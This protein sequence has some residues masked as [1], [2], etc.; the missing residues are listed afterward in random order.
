[1]FFSFGFFAH[2]QLLWSDVLSI[3]FTRTAKAN[4]KSEQVMSRL[5]SS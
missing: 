1:M 2:Q 3:Q 5:T 4:D